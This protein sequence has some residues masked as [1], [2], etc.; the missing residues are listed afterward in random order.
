LITDRLNGMAGV[1]EFSVDESGKTKA[2]WFVSHRQ[3]E[4]RQKAASLRISLL[5]GFELATPSGSIALADGSQ[6]LVAFVALRSRAVTRPEVWGTLWPDVTD[7]TASGR[8]RSALWRLTGAAS[9][10]L[11]ANRVNLRVA[12][13]VGVDLWDARAIAHRLL[14]DG[15]SVRK[16]DETRRTLSLLSLDILPEWYDDWALTEAEA[17]RQL[18]LHALE[19]FT[20]YLVAQG[21]YGEAALAAT[22][23]VRAEP[24]RESARLALIRV[25]LAE[26]N[27]SEAVREYQ[28]YRELLRV[29]LGVEPTSEIVDLTDGLYVTQR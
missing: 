14:D 2:S 24:L 18:R 27:R 9:T 13:G 20:G 26:G 12:D 11:H 16:T 25:H 15:A 29:E 1:F 3:D 23:A 7:Q 5:G 8:L 6:R 21:R 17:W 28:R 22:L 19:A 10:T 4:R